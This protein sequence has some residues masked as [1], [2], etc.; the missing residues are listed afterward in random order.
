MK[1]ESAIK[2]SLIEND[3]IDHI[4]AAVRPKIYIRSWVIKGTQIAPWK[5]FFTQLRIRADLLCLKAWG[6]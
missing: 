6:K 5:N 2:E 4:L 1:R 3:D